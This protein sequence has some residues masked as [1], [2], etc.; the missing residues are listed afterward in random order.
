[1]KKKLLDHAYDLAIESAYKSSVV[2]SKH[3]CS[4]IGER[5]GKLSVLATECNRVVMGHPGIY[6]MHAEEAALEKI[7]NTRATAALIVRVGTHSSSK[8]C[9]RCMKKL[10]NKNIN[11][12]Y[13][14]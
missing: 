2:K 8:P 1:M 13:F 12:I 9:Q 7:G 14:T 10:I 3:G 11:R 6:T 4:L 5:N